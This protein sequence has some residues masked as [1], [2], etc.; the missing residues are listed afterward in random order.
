[1]Y[2]KLVALPYIEVKIMSLKTVAVVSEH[3][4]KK[5]QAAE[6]AQTLKPP[7]LKGLT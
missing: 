7:G 1:M 3:K 4:A 6:A 5:K 2:A